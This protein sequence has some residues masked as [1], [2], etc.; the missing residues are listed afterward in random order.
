MMT[1]I[2]ETRMWSD[3]HAHFAQMNRDGE[4]EVSWIPGHVLSRDQAI[5]ATVVADFLTAKGT[6]DP[7]HLART[8]LNFLGHW[9]EELGMLTSEVLTLFE[10]AT[11]H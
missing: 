1:M 2:T 11:M 10:T 8:D 6:T 5:T 9:S 7:T 3:Q 4:W